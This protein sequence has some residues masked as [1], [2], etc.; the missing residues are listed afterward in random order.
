M[1]F[2][3]LTEDLIAAIKN[4]IAQTHEILDKPESQL[5][6]SHS[7]FTTPHPSGKL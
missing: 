5:F 2:L 6:Q 1:I 3:F 7:F 4:D